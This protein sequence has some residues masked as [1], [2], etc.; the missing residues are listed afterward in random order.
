MT[1]M[2]TPSSEPSDEHL[3]AAREERDAQAAARARRAPEE[4]EHEA[5][6]VWAEGQHARDRAQAMGDFVEGGRQPELGE[7]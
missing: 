3:D 1:D 5:E 7:E 6:E 2:P 4:R